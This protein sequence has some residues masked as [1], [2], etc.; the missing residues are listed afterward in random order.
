[1]MS[2]GNLP[3]SAPALI[4]AAARLITE[5]GW[6]NSPGGLNVSQAVLQAVG[7]VGIRPRDL[8][9][10]GVA[11]VDEVLSH[12]EAAHGWGMA[13]TEYESVHADVSAE[14]IAWDMVIVAWRYETQLA[15]C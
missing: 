2:D 3:P 7:G 6:I 13:V 14:L 5:Y 11:L 9:S 10:I 8:D 12:L 1:M 4:K 15:L